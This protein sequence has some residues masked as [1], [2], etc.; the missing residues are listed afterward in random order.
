[1]NAI[2]T[3]PVVYILPIANLAFKASGELSL[4]W[5]CCVGM[6]RSRLGDER[7]S[8]VQHVRESCP[9]CPLPMIPVNQNPLR[10]YISSTMKDLSARLDII[11]TRDARCCGCAP[12]V[13]SF[14]LLQ[15]LLS[16]GMC[17]LSPPALICL[18]TFISFYCVC[19]LL[20]A[21]RQ[22]FLPPS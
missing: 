10:G 11:K 22:E 20:E 15:R 5:T 14:V 9:S 17:L 2:L 12:I 8:R 19:H 21:N 7:L 4:S 13:E 16:I 3:R 1:M 6:A 18:L